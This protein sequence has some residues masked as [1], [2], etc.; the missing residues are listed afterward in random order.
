M[1]STF[2]EMNLM[3][4]IPQHCELYKSCFYLF[5]LNVTVD[6]FFVL[7]FSAED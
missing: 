1:V 6:L 2:P 7:V 5:S 3:Y 4:L